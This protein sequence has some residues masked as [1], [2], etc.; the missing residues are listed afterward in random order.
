M[1]PQNQFWTSSSKENLSKKGVI[2]CFTK[3]P[4]SCTIFIT[5]F[6]HLGQYMEIRENMGPCS[7]MHE[8]FTI[9]YPVSCQKHKTFTYI[10]ANVIRHFCNRVSYIRKMQHI[11][12]KNPCKIEQ[13]L[14][15]DC[16]QSGA[17]TTCPTIRTS[18]FIIQVFSIQ[19]ILVLTTQ[20]LNIVYGVIF[21]KLLD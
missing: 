19:L 1:R 13:W 21:D 14:N 3:L 4:F 2:H 6:R 15:Y 10:F 12:Y 20:I 17:L 18:Y 16:N 5:N 7:K 11:W 9:T 8:T